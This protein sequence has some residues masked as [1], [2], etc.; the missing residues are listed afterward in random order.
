MMRL[1]KNFGWVFVTLL[2]CSSQEEP[3]PTSGPGPNPSPTPIPNTSIPEISQIDPSIGTFE[4]V[5]KIKGNH[6]DANKVANEVKFN[7]KTAIV[8]ES[9]ITELIVSLPLDAGTGVVTVT[10]SAGTATGPEFI[11]LFSPKVTGAYPLMGK[12]NDLIT[13]LG[14]N[15][16]IDV[17]EL[18]VKINNTN[19]LVKSATPTEIVA[20][21]P[22]SAGSG[23][24]SVETPAGIV[25][26]PLFTYRYTAT[27]STLAGDGTF[28]YYDAQGLAA[29]MTY[30]AGLA[31]DEFDNI[32]VSDR[33]NNRI[34][35]ITQEG[36]VSTIIGSGL[37]TDTDGTGLLAN[38]AR[39]G[40]IL[41][42]N[43]GNYFFTAIGSGVIKKAT[44]ELVVT[45]YSGAPFSGLLDGPKDLSGFSFPTSIAFNSAGEL[46]VTDLSNS[47]IRKVSTDGSVTTLAGNGD[48]L[49]KD[50]T[51][52]D[53]SFEFPW[54]LIIDE[55]DNI[56]VSDYAC[57]RKITPEGV[58]TTYLGSTDGGFKD[59]PI[60]EAR[61]QNIYGIIR[62]VDGSI[63]ACDSNHAIRMIT[64]TGEVITLAGN[65]ETGFVD[66]V[67][68]DARF[69]RPS[70]ITM[71]SKGELFI[72]DRMNNAV[73]KMV[74][75]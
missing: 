16:D 27:V 3:T 21:V 69:N 10:T 6:F 29:K 73:R 62:W 25:S 60:A 7:G 15:F 48:F 12:Y 41:I 46:I 26:G 63:I 37:N 35:K 61:F 36:L 67:G 34:R 5:V 55:L 70:S 47:R 75:K 24:I 28:G 11:Y 52:T 51:G 39:P 56:F 68:S 40:G 58:V 66:G 65:G 71:N 54:G 19:A 8:L 13:I 72:G 44:P 20:Y 32:I 42:D 30:P 18:K 22:I 53:A 23:V 33:D 38:L 2:A 4:T 50:G 14:E 43:D 9:S 49:R 45:T 64:T 59:G 57:I 17:K 74:L 31:V 1:I